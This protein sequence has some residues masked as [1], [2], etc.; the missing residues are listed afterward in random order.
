MDDKHATWQ[1]EMVEAAI[2]EY[3]RYISVNIRRTPK[4]QDESADIRISFTGAGAWSAI[5][6]DARKI[7]K[8][9]TMN[10]SFLNSKYEDDKQ[11]QAQYMLTL[12][13]FGHALGLV[14]EWR[15]EKW[16]AL[17]GHDTS[18][19]PEPDEGSIMRYVRC[20]LEV[21]FPISQLGTSESTPRATQARVSVLRE[22]SLR[23]IKH[24]LPLCILE[25]LMELMK[26][27][28]S[29][30]PSKFSKFLLHNRLEFFLALQ[31]R[32]CDSIITST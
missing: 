24:G 7:S 31:F 26:V 1:S 11:H 25:R 3:S 22:V 14:H 17:G 13:Q 19:F 32:R 28:E 23:M 5:G 29:F 4:D 30:G 9:A 18:N 8:G 2:A 20:F 6:T 27:R 16:G 10:L 21:H 12:H 15:A